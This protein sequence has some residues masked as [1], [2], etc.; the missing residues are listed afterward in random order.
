ML[1][2]YG[3]GWHL[4]YSLL[5]PQ[6]IYPEDSKVFCYADRSLFSSMFKCASNSTE[7]TKNTVITGVLWWLASGKTRQI[8]NVLD[9]NAK[10]HEDHSEVPENSKIWILIDI[11]I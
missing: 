8:I 2:I 3:V 4:I 5:I 7:E 11:T 9:E 1:Q 6:K 10:S